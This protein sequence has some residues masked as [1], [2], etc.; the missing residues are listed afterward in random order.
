VV[1]T[2]LT[3]PFDG[4]ARV[5]PVINTGGIVDG[6]AF[7]LTTIAPGSW[8]SIFGTNLTDA[9]QGADGTNYAFANCGACNV[10]SQPLPMGIDGATISFDNSTQS[11]PGRLVYVQAGS[12]PQINVQVPWELTGSSAT[13]KAIVNYT[14]SP[15]YTLTIG[16]YSPAFFVYDSANDVSALDL[17]YHLIGSSNP[18]ARGSYAQLYMNG[19]G[20]VS[21]TAGP[22]SCTSGNLPADGFGAPSSPLAYTTTNPAC[23]IGGQPSTNIQFSG[24]APG[25]VSLYQVNAQIPTNI[26][27][28]AQTI[29]CSIGGV[30]TPAAQ[31]YVK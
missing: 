27:A 5:A 3:L 4:Y 26:S 19:L 13:V 1:G 9:T 15:E 22:P 6:A 23:T 2:S 24:L 12:A 29:T 8:I 14:Y 18:V 25:Y 11:L 31:L 28:G 30:T 16:Q 20:P 10:L 7:K 17:S 21:C